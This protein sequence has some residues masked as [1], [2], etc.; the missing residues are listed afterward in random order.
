MPLEELAALL[1]S[2]PGMAGKVAYYAFPLNEAPPLPYITYLQTAS[3]NMAADNRVYHKRRDVDVELYTE[4][5]DLNLENA[6]EAALDSAGI[7]W[8]MD[9]DYLNSER[10]YMLTYSISI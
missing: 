2:I 8:A 9:E 1:E 6:L 10:C 5:K 3:D 4:R 7:V